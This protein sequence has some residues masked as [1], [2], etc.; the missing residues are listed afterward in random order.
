[1]II[2]SREKVKRMED[3]QAG[4]GI[5][6]QLNNLMSEHFSEKEIQLANGLDVGVR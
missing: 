5:L 4:G 1:M 6:L 2:C 3:A